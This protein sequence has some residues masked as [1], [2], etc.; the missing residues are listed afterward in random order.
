M[1]YLWTPWRYA[2]ITNAGKPE[3]SNSCIFCE[4]LKLADPEARI[5]HR[6]EHCFVILNSFPYTSGH[7]MVVPF[8]HL[9]ELKKLPQAAPNEM[10]V[11]CEKMEAVM[12]QDTPAAGTDA[13]T[14]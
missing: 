4:L 1:D 2:Y 11:L 14:A 13:R 9:D 12:R 7:V 6:A 8:A 3:T 10:M 5:V